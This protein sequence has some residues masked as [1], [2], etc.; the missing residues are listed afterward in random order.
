MCGP[1]LT[2]AWPAR[3]RKCVSV[4][5][6]ADRS[7]EGVASICL[8]EARIADLALG[9]LL[10]RGLRNLAVFRFNDM[11]FARTRDRRFSEG[12][13]RVTL[14]ADRANPTSK[15]IDQD[16]GYRPVGDAVM[17]EFVE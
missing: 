8:D 3:L 2:G 9:H 15:R 11:A 7:A 14:S 1:A 6:N 4:V 10:S 13:W 12:A 17:M 16:I 5:V